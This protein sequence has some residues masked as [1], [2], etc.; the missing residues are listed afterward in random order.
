MLNALRLEAPQHS[1][2]AACAAVALPQFK[3]LADSA[4]YLE[5]AP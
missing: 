4:L 1:I 2:L 5:F 3:H